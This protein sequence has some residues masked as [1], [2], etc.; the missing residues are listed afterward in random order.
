MDWPSQLAALQ[1]LDRTQAFGQL[2]EVLASLPEPPAEAE[3]DLAY[4]QGKCALIAGRHAEAL[5]PLARCAA[6]QPARA[7]AHYLLGVALARQQLWPDAVD[8]C[9]R[10]LALEPELLAAA[11][12][13]AQAELAL[14]HPE[15]ALAVLEPREPLALGDTALHTTLWQARLQLAV[16]D[17]A[18]AVIEQALQSPQRLG[19]GLLLEWLHMAAGWFLAGRI[20]RA[21]AWFRALATPSPSADACGHPLPRRPALLLALIAELLNP[22]ADPGSLLPELRL[23]FWLPSADREQELWAPVIVP[24]LEMLLGRL[25][26]DGLS[27]ESAPEALLVVAELIRP[28]EPPGGQQAAA[29]AQQL[30]QLAAGSAPLGELTPQ[31]LTHLHQDLPALLDHWPAL[32]SLPD[33]ELLRWR[34]ELDQAIT[35]LSDLVLD[36]PNRLVI[37]PAPQA[38]TE[39]MALRQRGLAV[40]LA[41]QQRL[42]ALLP[43][44]PPHQRPRRRWLLLAS[45]DLPQCFLFRVEQKRQQLEALGCDCRILLRPDLESWGWS[46]QLLWADALIVCRLPALH[47]VLRAIQA[48]RLA[49]L[50]VYYDI[51]DLIIDPEHCPP[52]LESYGGT[53]NPELHRRFGLDVPLFAEAIRSCDGLI[54]STTA[55]A[56]RWMQLNECESADVWVLPNLAP[57]QLRQALRAPRP[58]RRHEPLRL[59]LASGTT[60]HKQSW[61]G[62]LAPALA[63]LMARRPNLRL[64]LLGH[65]QLPLVLQPF[66]ARIHC[67]PYADYPRY[68]QQLGQAAIGL[69]VLEAGSFTDAKSAIRWMEFSYLGLASVLS[70]TATYLESL[71]PGVHALFASG[72]EQWVEQIEALIT[73]PDRRLQLARQAQAHAQEL[74]GPHQAE[75]CWAPLLKASWRAQASEGAA[76]PRKLLMPHV[77]Y[78][79]QLMGGATRV[80]CDQ[81]QALQHQAGAEWEIT[82]LCTDHT[83]WQQNAGDHP[84]PWNLDAPIPVQIHAW[85]GV[86]VVRLA[87]PPRPW[88]EHHDASV[89]RF[90]R[91]WLTQEGFDLIHAHCLQVLSAAPLQVAR[92]LGIP[93]SIT[94]HDGWWISPRQFLI[95][96]SGAAVDPADP[97]S[98][99]D[100][101]HQQPAALLQRDQER[102]QALAELLAGAAARWAVSEP[103]AA[104]HRQAGVADVTVMENRW[105]PMPAPLPRTVRPAHL[106]LRACFIGGLSLHKGLAV[107]QAALLQARWPDPGLELTLVD[108]AL[109][110]GASY[111]LRWGQTPLQVVPGVPMQAMAAFYAEHDVLIA[112]SIWP[113]SY[114]LV[115]R[116]ALSAGLWVVASAA[117]ALKEPIRHGQNGHVVPMGDATALAQ[118][119][120]ALCRDHPT[121][122]PL[123]AFNATDHP[124][125]QEL[126][127]RYRQLLGWG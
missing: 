60:A 78:G 104:L 53:L 54:A 15:A 125:G 63:E 44:M 10:A 126:N 68:L 77:F 48:A 59:V 84:E 12:E 113:E 119:L 71:E 92:N 69:V 18:P 37:H 82:V 27:G 35:Q 127:Q 86:R 17:Q 30:Q 100:A 107:L 38:Q 41:A 116:E 80:V 57:P 87:L 25:Q 96:A 74:F 124:L 24:A 55:L 117:G 45:D 103:F 6:L 121:P 13:L 36:R 16:P 114:G 33:Q 106:P 51:D 88:R 19:D 105:Q 49:G 40:L 34:G 99:Y 23:C 66:A 52:P 28:L 62:E 1:E 72:S 110:P 29:L 22:A 58:L 76:Q 3:G 91:W 123:L 43:A 118:V 61:Q 109:E 122:Q 5:A 98:H 2:A 101:P 56:Q 11:V 83:P 94:L 26:L 42:A 21:G 111:S 102:R 67:R 93:Y 112:P 108:A 97:L 20:E 31:R 8:V 95:T 46:E 39:A 120:E 14:G 115:T 32:L 65:L 4:W 79:P 64:D 89:E 47:G 50:P 75:R 85:D 90:C 7:H 81:L 9:R 73:D 70:P